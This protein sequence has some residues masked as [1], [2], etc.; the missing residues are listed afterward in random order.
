M[1]RISVILI[2]LLFSFNCFAQAGAVAKPFSI[3]GGTYGSAIA[4]DDFSN[5][6]EFSG[7]A[8]S[9]GYAFGASNPYIRL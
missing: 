8:F 4:S 2:F 9:F 3:G 7:I 1:K 5:D 6:I